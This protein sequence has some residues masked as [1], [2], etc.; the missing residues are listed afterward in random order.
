MVTQHVYSPVQ[1]KDSFKN[2]MPTVGMPSI[3]FNLV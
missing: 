3:L 2:N 1:M